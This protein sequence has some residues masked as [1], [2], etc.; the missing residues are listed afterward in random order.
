[1][2]RVEKTVFITFARPTASIFEAFDDICD[3]V[4]HAHCNL[5]SRYN[6][7]LKVVGKAKFVTEWVELRL[8]I[9][10]DLANDFKVGNRLRGIAA[11]LLKENP[12]KYKPYLVGNRLLTFLS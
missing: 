11:W 9:P 10:E 5:L 8:S 7:K 6:V 12:D 1:M 3:A 2:N 4:D